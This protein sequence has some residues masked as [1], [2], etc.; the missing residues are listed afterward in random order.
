[1]ISSNFSSYGALET[2]VFHNSNHHVFSFKKYITYFSKQPQTGFSLPYNINLRVSKIYRIR[3]EQAQFSLVFFLENRVSRR[4]CFQERQRTVSPF[5]LPMP[6]PRSQK[7]ICGFW[8][9]MLHF[10]EWCPE[11]VSFCVILES[12]RGDNKI[13]IC[14]ILLCAV[15]SLRANS[16]NSHIFLLVDFKKEKNLFIS[17]W[18]Y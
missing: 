10:W 9:R 11:H 8:E 2:P 13:F 7:S 5:V 16:C 6:P 15:I 1:M 14:C 12:Q 18:P 3:E 4:L 17:F